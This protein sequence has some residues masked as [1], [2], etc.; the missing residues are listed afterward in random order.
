M[1][2]SSNQSR[3]QI[4]KNHSQQQNPSFGMAVDVDIKTIQAVPRLTGSRLEALREGYKDYYVRLRFKKSGK[5]TAYTATKPDRIAIT[6]IEKP[7]NQVDKL[8]KLLF[9]QRVDKTVDISK[10]DCF[11]AY[12]ASANAVEAKVAQAIKAIKESKNKS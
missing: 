11:T 2:I 5:E 10:N 7:A 1:Q 3:F 4:S 8:W 9:G 12:N 6:V